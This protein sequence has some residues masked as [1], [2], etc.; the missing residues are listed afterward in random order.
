MKEYLRIRNRG[1]GE[2]VLYSLVWAAIF[3][4]PFM[5]AHLMSEREIDFE[6][7]IISWGKIT[8]YFIIF[9]VNNFILTPK[10][11]LKRRYWQYIISLIVV[12]VAV[13]ATIE[14]SDF[15]YWQY[16]VDLRSKA[17]LTELKWY[18]NVLFSVL[19]AGANAM[20]KIYYQIVETERHMA[21]LQK[22]NVETQ[23]QYLKY[24]INPHFLM[25]TLNNIHA[26]IDFD[27]DKAKQS[28]MELSRM[29][30][31]VLYDSGESETTL[32]KEVDFLNNYIALMRLRYVDDVV[33]TLSV[34]DQQHCRKVYMPPLLLI[35]LIE[36]AFKHGISYTNPSYINISIDVDDEKLK[37]LV[38]NSC[39]TTSNVNEH[40][41][42]GLSNIKKR[43][44][45]LFD[46]HYSLNI[47]NS[48]KQ[49]YR[50]ELIIPINR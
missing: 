30:R 20:I 47:D 24:Q 10:L 13:F 35:V 6:K 15:R 31:H 34:P 19:M 8:P 14:I 17:S 32:D 1:I 28:V 50:V 42:I 45:L 2:N 33:I 22:Q 46:S 26:M 36:N 5:N 25:N 38:V 3:L 43:L 27:S 18:W 4:I 12:V 9:V 7:V 49:E 48:N 44:D 39:H 16:N 23:M 21:I 41:G 40:S 29:M 11:L 37:C